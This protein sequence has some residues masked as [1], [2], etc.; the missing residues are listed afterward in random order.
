MK[1]G[2]N[3]RLDGVSFVALSAVQCTGSA[4]LLV[5]SRGS[6]VAA[7]LS[8][9]QNRTR[10]R[11]PGSLFHH[12]SLRVHASG[13]KKASSRGAFGSVTTPRCS[14]P[15][16]P[17]DRSGLRR[18]RCSDAGSRGTKSGHRAASAANFVASDRHISGPKDRKEITRW[19]CISNG[20]K[21]FLASGRVRGEEIPNWLSPQTS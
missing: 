6:I 14:G 21:R 15:P 7:V 18:E 12:P 19:V 13:I 2:E 16:A 8:A 10:S 3:A 17:R 9:Q 20:G 1:Q 5:H 4:G 11:R